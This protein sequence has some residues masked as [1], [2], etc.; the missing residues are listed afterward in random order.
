M[1]DK[2]TAKVFCP[3][4]RG[5]EYTGTAWLCGRHLA[6]TAAHCIGD[7]IPNN[8]AGGKLWE[9]PYRLVFP[10]PENLGKI[11]DVEL[12]DHDFDLDVAVFRIPE[13]RVPED[14]P[15]ILPATLPHL[16][17]PGRVDWEAWGFPEAWTEGTT[18]LGKVI[19]LDR[20]SIDGQ[21]GLIELT[22][23]QGGSGNL[24]GASGAALVVE[25]R[26]V[27]VLRF[28]PA[29]FEARHILASPMTALFQR[30]PDLSRALDL[31]T[32]SVLVAFV[33]PDL[34]LSVSLMESLPKD[35]VQIAW[36]QPLALDNL[37]EARRA[38]AHCAVV[39]VVWTRAFAEA[40]VARAFLAYI[41]KQRRAIALNCLVLLV[42][43]DVERPGALKKQTF[44][45]L[46]RAEGYDPLPVDDLRE[47]LRRLAT[48]SS[49]ALWPWLGEPLHTDLIIQPVEGTFDSLGSEVVELLRREAKEQGP[50]QGASTSEIP[51]RH[52]GGLAAS[53]GQRSEKADNI[54]SSLI[55]EAID[56]F[57]KHA[58][59]YY[60]V[61]VRRIMPDGQIMLTEPRA[62]LR[63]HDVPSKVW[64][65]GISGSGRGRIAQLFVQTIDDARSAVLRGDHH[66][67]DSAARLIPIVVTPSWASRKS[68]SPLTEA[69]VQ[70]L[71]DPG[72]LGDCWLIVDDRFR[73]K[74]ITNSFSPESTKKRVLDLYQVYPELRRIPR[75]LVLAGAGQESDSSGW[76]EL[77]T[78][79]IVVDAIDDPRAREMVNDLFART[80]TL[81]VTPR[82]IREVERS[83]ARGPVANLGLALLEH[84]VA[85]SAAQV[86]HPV[87]PEFI[88]ETVLP[89][90]IAGALLRNRGRMPVLGAADVTNAQ[91]SRDLGIPL[92]DLW[93]VIRSTPGLFR[94]RGATELEVVPSVL[95]AHL[96]ARGLIADP[97]APRDAALS[98]NPFESSVN[99]ELERLVAEGYESE[100]VPD[101]VRIA[102]VPPCE[103][104]EPARILAAARSMK[105]R[106]GR[107]LMRS[108]LGPLL[109]NRLLPVVDSP[110]GRYLC[111]CVDARWAARWAF[112]ALTVSGINDHKQAASLLT[113][114]PADLVEPLL[115]LFP[116]ASSL[117]AA[118]IST[119]APQRYVEHL[120]ILHREDPPLIPADLLDLLEGIEG[121]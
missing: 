51:R 89:S 68:D 118:I 76:V 12:I 3:R 27:G 56:H 69:A 74:A 25:G 116:R 58:K 102:H 62:L 111:G 57:G 99:A 105:P 5:G 39:L 13:D 87:D 23:E 48:G 121:A 1:L 24:S 98:T 97:S 107:T 91:A 45:L 93:L 117:L 6:V 52:P 35:D 43:P 84:A 33:S 115:Q 34:H 63:A 29:E 59:T 7:R 82:M 104:V 20:A 94:R 22:C 44:V 96:A 83:G 103:P 28:A 15:G 53:V 71:A 81:I 47:S 30:F 110:E 64:L 55:K 95:A 79:G 100:Y 2:C 119:R 21:G 41:E 54:V 65:T 72:L 49:P 4:A 86:S 109:C 112:G 37:D 36:R 78:A 11:D 19:A 17:G 92:A 16:P 46:S 14:V 60:P 120:R 18:L 75:V 50:S 38:L 90:V 88:L 40:P 114:L 106:D 8:P 67:A 9:G 77:A 61:L 80:G 108:H 73:P 26:A 32:V 70:A 85:E 42:D 66:Y 10:F 113:L 31:R 101:L